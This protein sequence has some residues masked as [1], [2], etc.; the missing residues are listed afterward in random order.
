MDTTIYDNYGGHSGASPTRYTVQVPGLYLLT[1]NL[2]WGG[3]SATY[4]IL[5]ILVNGSFA[6]GGRVTAIG[7]SGITQAMN[8]STL[9]QLNVGDYVEMAATSGTAVA[10]TTNGT[11]GPY[12]TCTWVSNS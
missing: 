9:V 6:P 8:V 7:V 3:N 5:D 10:T 1:A 11:Y 4:R 12:L 2:G